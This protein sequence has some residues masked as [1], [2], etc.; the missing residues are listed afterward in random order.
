MTATS[1]HQIELAPG[2]AICIPDVTWEGYQ[3]LPAQLGNQRITRFAYDNGVLEIRMLG[4]PH[5]AINRVLAAIAQV[6][7]LNQWLQL[8]KTGTDLTV[9]RAVRQFCRGR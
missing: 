5:K 1:I 6:D 3:A 8:R 2:S 4:Q 7:Q 9:V